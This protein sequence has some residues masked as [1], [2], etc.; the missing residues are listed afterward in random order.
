MFYNAKNGEIEIENTTVNYISFGK[1]KRNLIIIP[2]VGDGFKTVKG[3]AIP[4][5][6][7][8]KL[9]AKDFTVYVFSRRNIIKDG[10]STKDMANDIINHMEK[11][12]IDKAD[13]V[14]VSQGGMIA[15]HIAIKEPEKVNKLVLAVT[16]PRNN[17]VL[18]DVVT[19]WIEKAKSKDYKG[20]MIDNAEKS[21]TGKYLEKNRKV[22]SLLGLLGK[23]VN[24]ERFIIQAKS[25]LEHN[26]Y[27][28][29]DK[30][31]AKTLII[32]AKQ[33]KVLGIIGSEE[34]AEKITNSELYI[35]DGYSHGVYEQA[36]DFNNRILEYLKQN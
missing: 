11:L 7:M 14:G 36:K 24:Y 32:G 20:I 23:N 16:A 3:L 4:F 30:I 29:L 9:F 10:F 5:A 2:G 26:S 12:N 19:D 17:E 21:Y 28:E 35:Y 31:K 18:N 27:D 25:C 33:D 13:I 34:M 8:Y 1:G 15:Q 6:F 22:Y